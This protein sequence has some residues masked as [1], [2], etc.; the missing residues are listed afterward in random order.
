MAQSKLPKD[1]FALGSLTGTLY[2]WK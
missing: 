2:D 1:T